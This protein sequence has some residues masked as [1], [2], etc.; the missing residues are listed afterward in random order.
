M[1]YL[2]TA[3][4]AALFALAVATIAAPISAQAQKP[5]EKPKSTVPADY[6]I[7]PEDILIIITRDMPEASG[8]F[9]VRP[10]GTIS[11]PV[12]GVIKASGL[13]PNQL[14][15]TLQEAL[16]KELREP[17]VTV[18]VKQ[19]RINRIY[20][21]GLVSRPSLYDYKPGWRLTELIAASGGLAMT[22]E[23]LTAVV[24]RVGEPNKTVTMRGLFV[25][26]NE[27]LNLVLQPGDVVNIRSEA[28]IRVSVVGQVA[29]P[30][31]YDIQEGM[32]AAEAVAAA[33]GH[34]DSAALAKALVRRSAQDIKVNLYEVIGKAQPTAN[35][36]LK[37]GD[38]VFVPELNERVSVV[39]TVNRPGTHLIPDGRVYTVTQAIS[40]AGGPAEKAKMEGVYVA[41]QLGDGKIQQFK[42]NYKAITEAKAEDFALQDRDVVFVPKS[43]KTDTREVGGLL[44]IWLLAGRLF[45]LP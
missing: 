17:V 22:P 37:D 18:N 20:I 3:R 13:T 15:A 8:D 2:K 6:V 31:Q 41:R 36:L 25:D 32:G 7:G 16:K 27:D 10:D 11:F 34:R 1:N 33:G 4:L 40:D 43:G 44:N 45:G 24:F 5:A 35:V 38:T 30:G 21:L 14:Q 39:G 12:A 9:M 42:L 23:R 19:M 26:G 28:T 29:R